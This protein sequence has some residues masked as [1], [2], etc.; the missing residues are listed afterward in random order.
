MDLFDVF[1]C[2][3]LICSGIL[4]GFRTIFD[5]MEKNYQGFEDGKILSCARGGKFQ[6]TRNLKLAAKAPE[7]MAGPKKETN[8]PTIN[9]QAL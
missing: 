4:G 1:F 3:P 6:H 7:K 5:F 8:L 9:F 2:F